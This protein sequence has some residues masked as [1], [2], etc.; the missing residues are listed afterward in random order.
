[1]STDDLNSC[2]FVG[3]LRT[4][5]TKDFLIKL[6]KD[7]KSSPNLANILHPKTNF[8][9]ILHFQLILPILLGLRQVPLL[10]E[11]CCHVRVHGGGQG[12]SNI[13]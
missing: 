1:M 4:L 6:I 2:I 12:W 10:H 3:H 8:A 11:D 13:F 7:Y 9:N 5:F